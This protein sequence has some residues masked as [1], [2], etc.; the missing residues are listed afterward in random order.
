MSTVSTTGPHPIQ[1]IANYELQR[2][3]QANVM[4]TAAVQYSVHVTKEV[5]DKGF[6]SSG[7]SMR[8]I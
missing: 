6:H 2:N 5:R 3:L 8:P 4:R 1:E 7:P